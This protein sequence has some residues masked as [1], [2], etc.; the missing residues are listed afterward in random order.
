[1]VE[2]NPDWDPENWADESP[3]D[4]NLALSLQGIDYPFPKAIADVVD[5]SISHGKAENVWIDI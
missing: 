5:N 2:E 3:P 1:M 4:S